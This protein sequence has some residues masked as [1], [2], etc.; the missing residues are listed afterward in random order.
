MVARA[1]QALAAALETPLAPGLHIVSTPIG[2]LAD[3]TLRALSVLARADLI[4]CED[5]RHSARLLRHYGLDVPL[6]PYHDHNAGRVRP[7]VLKALEAGQSVALISDAGT[8]LVSDPGYKLVRAALAGG[9]KVTSIPGPSA[10]LAALTASGLPSDR[11]H[12]EGFLPPR[13]TA[14]RRR[15][16]EL[17]GL[18]ATLIFYESAQRVAAMLRDAAHSFGTREAVLAR[19][20]TKMHE[21]IVRG[22]VEELVEKLGESIPLKGEFVVL[23]APAP[24][25]AVSEAQIMEALEEALAHA[26]LRDAARDVADALGVSRSRVYALALALQGEGGAR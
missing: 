17:A 8:P 13:Q 14:R 19:E 25:G 22:S 10:L 5:T 1:Q 18:P 11:F 4:L 16:T 7:G 2:N 6:Q 20:L 21:Q 26:S 9:H 12:F 23:V 15:L 3:I 24:A